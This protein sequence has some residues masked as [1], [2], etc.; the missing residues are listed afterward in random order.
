MGNHGMG[1]GGTGMNCY[2]MGWG[3]K[4]CLMDKSEYSASVHLCFGPY[5]SEVVNGFITRSA[6][7]H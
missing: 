2:G 5:S 3:R 7:N 1:W 6:L 4:I